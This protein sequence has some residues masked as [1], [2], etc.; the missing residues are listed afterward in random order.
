VRLRADE[1]KGGNIGWLIDAAEDSK[2]LDVV[3]QWLKAEPFNERVLNLKMQDKQGTPTVSTPEQ[4]CT[5]GFPEKSFANVSR[6]GRKQPDQNVG[7][8]ETR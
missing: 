6:S 4:F 2:G 3:L 7:G 1:W 5:V 8:C